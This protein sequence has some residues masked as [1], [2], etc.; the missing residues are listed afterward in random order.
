MKLDLT[1]GDF[2]MN[3]QSLNFIEDKDYVLFS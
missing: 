1:N 2:E 3:L